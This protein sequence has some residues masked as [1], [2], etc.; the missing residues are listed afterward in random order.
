VVAAGDFGQKRYYPTDL[1]AG[2]CSP[3][4]VATIGL[5]FPFAKSGALLAGHSSLSS[6]N[7]G[8]GLALPRGGDRWPHPPACRPPPNDGIRRIPKYRTA[9]SNE[10]AATFRSL[11]ESGDPG[12][13]R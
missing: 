2:A 3:I 7:A 11:I 13:A 8:A 1:S 12:R 9:G 4:R 5:S 6:G 10:L